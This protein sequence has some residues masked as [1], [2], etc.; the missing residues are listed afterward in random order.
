M[1][2]RS[3]VA[4]CKRNIHSLTV[5]PTTITTTTSYLNNNTYKL[6]HKDWLS[7]NEILKIFETLNDPNSIIPTLNQYTTRKDYKPTEQLYTLVINKLAQAKNYHAIDTLMKRIK[8]EKP[9]CRLSDQFFYNVIKTYGL[10]AFRI[11]TSVDVLYS[12]PDYNCWPSVKTFNFVLNLLVSNKLYEFVREVYEKANDLG[13]EIDSCCLNI[14]IK[15]LCES[16]NLDGAF[17]VLDEFPKQKCVPNVRTYSTL[18]HAL[19]D[20]GRMDEAFGLLDRMEREN[21]EP[22]TITFN[23][24]ISGLRK[25]GRVEEGIELFEMMKRKG[26]CPSPSSYQEVLYGLLDARKFEEAK[27]FMGRMISEGASPSFLSYKKLMQGFCQRKL[28]DDVDKVLKQMVRQGFVPRMG[29][30]REMVRCLLPD[31]NSF[32]STSLDDIME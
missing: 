18:M 22:D 2:P 1:T 27:L 23:I 5:K 13:V 24:L 26:C 32:Y 11:K 8:T 28:V 20:D 30:W 10:Y 6:N 7:T 31:N 17:Y 9:A 15:G 14:L 21:V 12:M 4:H 3:L 19:C 29:M 16:G 25:Q